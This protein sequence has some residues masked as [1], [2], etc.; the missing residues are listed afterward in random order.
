MKTTYIK[1]H[2]VLGQK[3]GVRNGPPYPI[4]DKVLRKG[5]VLKNVSAATK[6]TPIEKKRGAIYTYGNDYDSKVYRGPFSVYL[7]NMRR[8]AAVFER[9]FEVA[10]DLKLPTSK[11]RF[12]EFESLMSTARKKAYLEELQN[13]QKILRQYGIAEREKWDVDLSNYDPSDQKQVKAAY[14]VF[15]H[16]M[17][18]K[19]RFALTQNY[20]SAMC[21]KYDAM[22]DDN[23]VNSYNKAQDPLIIFNSKNL[24]VLES[25]R[26][27]DEEILQCYSEIKEIMAAEGKRVAL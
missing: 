8:Y 19:Q 1:H 18:E 11:E 7:R 12:Q 16:M 9:T 2:G 27:S 5:T 10:K 22:V 25:R 3:W 24:K 17:E 13:M 20:Y 23:N 6:I 15:N 14:M 21:K 26:V 4:E